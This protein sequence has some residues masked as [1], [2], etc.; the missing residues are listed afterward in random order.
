MNSNELFLLVL[1]IISAVLLIP[2]IRTVIIVLIIATVFIGYSITKNWW[3][4]FA[5]AFI[6]GNIYAALCGTS[7]YCGMVENF[8]SSTTK[9][10]KKKTK[11]DENTEDIDEETD[12]NNEEYFIDSKESMLENYKMLTPKQIKGLNK[13][14]QELISTQK[15]LIE[16][17]K[18]MGPALKDGKNILDTFKNYFGDEK[19][20]NKMMKNFSVN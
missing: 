16:T 2:H 11:V 13:D 7:P 6:L 18:N 3:Y 15:N 8:K 19:D 1:A 14:T 5:V 4:S 12:V 9:K 10:T 20:I 17:L